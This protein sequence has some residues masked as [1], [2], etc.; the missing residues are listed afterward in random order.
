MSGD[1]RSAGFPSNDPPRVQVRRQPVLGAALQAAPAAARPA[2]ACAQSAPAGLPDRPIQRGPAPAR[3]VSNPALLARP[4]HNLDAA[5]Q[6]N[7]DAQTPHRAELA[8]RLVRFGLRVLTQETASCTRQL[9]LAR[10]YMK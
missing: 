1:L 6:N 4:V 7:D 8:A 2:G 9:M 10:M 3:P 5:A